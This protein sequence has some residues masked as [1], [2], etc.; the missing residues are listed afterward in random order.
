MRT[1]KLNYSSWQYDENEP[2]A[3]PGGFGQVFKGTDE[4]GKEVAIKKLF[5]DSQALGH[6][7]LNIARELAGGKYSHIIPFFDSGIDADSG[8]Y[9]IVMAKA[10]GS[11]NDQLTNEGLPTEKTIAILQDIALGLREV[12]NIVHR[13]LKPANVLFHEGVWKIADFGI[14]RFIEES[15]SVN[16]LKDFLS[17]QYAAPEQWQYETSTKATDVYA[18]GCIGYALLTGNP[19]F[20]SGDLRQQHLHSEPSPLSGDPRLCQLLSLCLRKNPQVRPAIDSV[21]SQLE[22]I[23]LKPHINVSALASAAASVAQEL[24][25][26]EAEEARKQVD[27]LHRKQ[28]VNDG[29]Q[30]LELLMNDLFAYIREQAPNVGVFRDNHAELGKGILSFSFVFPFLQKG[31]FSFSGKDVASGALIMVSQ[32][33]TTYEGRSANLWFADFDLSGKFRWWE[34]CYFNL[35]SHIQTIVPFGIRRLEEI[36]DVDYAAGPISHSVNHAAKPIPIDGEFIQSFI[37]RWSMR[38][39]KASL[40]QLQSPSRL[41]E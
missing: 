2:L 25:K 5:L 38:L 23:A 33:S 37:E 18:L 8:E 20:V 12:P 1:I 41:P 27:L 28:L 29:K 34:I 14:A 4:N 36:R 9:F 39:A 17:A 24:A 13:D 30:I 40:N 15:T 6:R 3:P 7:E 21:T 22:S 19:P 10:D 16:T 32:K 31:L 26:T 35:N 11:L